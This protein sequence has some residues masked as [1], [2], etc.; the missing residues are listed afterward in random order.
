MAM[1]I[2]PPINLNDGWM[3]E[4][5]GHDFAQPVPSLR[6]FTCADGVPVRLTRTFDVPPMLDVCLRFDL[7]ISAAPAATSLIING[8]PL[9]EIARAAPFVLDVTDVIM[10]EDNLIALHTNC[11]SPGAFGDISLNAEACD[12]QPLA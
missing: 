1:S 9:G 11:A 10:L 5:P 4:Y 12:Q 8:R 2:P 3:A 7:R 6:D